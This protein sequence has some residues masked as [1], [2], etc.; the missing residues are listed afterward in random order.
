MTTHAD[1]IFRGNA[2]DATR[3]GREATRAVTGVETAARRS[4]THLNTLGASAEKNQ[5]KLVGFGNATNLAFGAAGLAYG[6]KSS[7]NAFKDAQ[8]QMARVSASLH[9]LGIDNSAT[10][11]Q[12]EDV[13]LA[14][15]RL[16]GFQDDELQR[17]FATLLRSTKDVNE[18]LRIN[19]I[20][21]DFARG[22]GKDL[23]V[24]ATAFAKVT[25]GN[26]NALAR[27]GI[28][29]EKGATVTEVLAKAQQRYA[30][31]AA[32]YGKTVA[33]QADIAAGEF[34]NLQEV[35]GSK[36]GPALN[37]AAGGVLSFTGAVDGLASSVGGLGPLVVG[38]TGFGAFTLAAPVVGR[39]GGLLSTISANS[40]ASGGGIRGMAS[41]LGASVSPMGLA[42]VGA[43]ILAGG[44]YEI[45]KNSESADQAV[46]GLN[47]TLRDTAA[48]RGQQETAKN[49]VNAAKDYVKA[50]GDAVKA[51]RDHA[52]ALHGER[53][54]LVDNVKEL[55]N[56]GASASKIETAQNKVTA[57]T[58]EWRK[59]LD[60]IVPAVHA[61]QTA[62]TN[63]N[64][65]QTNLDNS[66]G[67]VNAALAE[68][69]RK[70]RDVIA[71]SRDA[72]KEA[73]AA[74][75]RFGHM[76]DKIYDAGAA[77]E[78]FAGFMD[79][80]AAKTRNTDSATSNADSTLAAFARRIGRLPTVREVRLVTNFAA[81][82]LSL[83]AIQRKLQAIHDRKVT[84]QFNQT[85]GQQI[86]P[87]T[88]LVRPP[89]KTPTG[90]TG[91]MV[92]GRYGDGDR[93]L[94]LLAGEEAV[95][96][97]QQ[98]GLVDG[99]MTVREA[100]ATTGAPTIGNGF[101]KGKRPTGR[102]AAEHR[103]PNYNPK[104]PPTLAQRVAKALDQ[105]SGAWDLAEAQARV[106]IA[107]ADA[108]GDP[109]GNALAYEA[110][111]ATEDATAR[112]IRAILANPAK[113]LGIK[114]AKLTRDERTR[115]FQA[116]ASAISQAKSDRDTAY[117]LRHPD[118]SAP[119]TGGGDTGASSGDT[120]PTPD[121]EAQTAQLQ[122]RL[123]IATRSA[124]LSEAE[125]RAFGSRGDIGT[126]AYGNAFDAARGGPQIV[127]LGD[128]R[129]AMAAAAW[130]TQG[131][132]L[133]PSIPANRAF[134]GV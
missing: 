87:L 112:A 51:A 15:Q 105:K 123:A 24:V 66:T 81:Q 21:A 65:A 79:R 13:T 46:Q 90:A 36:F 128:A 70:T 29:A 120:G 93:Q 113:A 133:Q 117:G 38:A 58:K 2:R 59:A 6:I 121:Q 16:S 41:A 69:D 31:Q 114:G 11:K 8:V 88:G 45:W 67:G 86:D 80:A 30:G 83:D 4:T 61:Q 134:I 25:D 122:T 92:A 110:E 26:V 55:R 76:G 85:F 115:L 107:T 94:A 64:S 39:F 97:P 27:Y 48:A 78:A 75:G 50:T 96:T 5:K 68:Q 3:A 52:V 12:I 32:A 7:V 1:I 73:T 49:N 63:L 132:G 9:T 102:H 103:N 53:Q 56:H 42:A 62:T 118:T 35:I 60:D 23:N 14:Q 19:A 34:N 116:L 82:G 111:A 22:S 125:V 47:S 119:D 77:A 129:S 89:K 71:K 91:G 124:A 106:R 17:S 72:A 40:K 54:A 44:I 104:E 126:G 18:A 130:F 108:A 127:M 20:V 57:K 109:T 10:R 37:V 131:A 100:L 43:G 101:A 74:A 33:G 28:K 84:I 99:G 95:L 98:Q